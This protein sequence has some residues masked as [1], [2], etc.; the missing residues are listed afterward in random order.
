MG[1]KQRSQK[2]MIVGAFIIALLTFTKWFGFG[3]QKVD[4]D[5]RLATRLANRT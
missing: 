1:W 3:L 5:F 4:I 2:S